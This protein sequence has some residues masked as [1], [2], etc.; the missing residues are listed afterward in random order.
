VA[1]PAACVAVLVYSRSPQKIIRAL[2]F[3]PK[4]DMVQRKGRWGMAEEFEVAEPPGLAVERLYRRY[5]RDVRA[6]V[7]RSFGPG[8]PD[9][10][11]IAQDAFVRLMGRGNLGNL[12]NPRAHLLATA[13]N[14]A[15]DAY[16]RTVTGGAVIRTIGVVEPAFEELDAGQA[17]ASKIE[18]EKLA[19]IMA[20]LDPKSRSAFLMHRI[21]GLSFSE[22]ARRTGTSPSGARFLVAR[23]L[24]ACVAGMED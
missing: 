2:I 23:A 5:W 24:A 21:D 22:I 8:P 7:R 14:L 3:E 15:V 19:R 20:G 10:D 6:Y 4:P 17:L 18:L 12:T 11:D 1:S 13:R 16:R 9:P